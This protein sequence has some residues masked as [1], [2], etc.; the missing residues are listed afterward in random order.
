MNRKVMA[1]I[2]AAVLAAAALMGCGS[3]TATGLP[4][5]IEVQ[6]PAKAGGGTDVMARTLT[7]Q[8]SKDSGS[9]FAIV[10]NTDGAGLVAAEKVRTAKADGSE[11]MQWHTT[12]LIKTATGLYDKTADKDFRIIAVSQGTDKA[13]Y[14]LVVNGTSGMTTMADLV[15]KAQAGEVKMGVETGGTSHIIGGLLAKAAGVEFKYVESGSDTEKLTALVGGTIDCAIV[16][17]NQAKQYVESGKA[18]ALG[19]VGNGE[20]GARSSI[21]PDVKNMQEQ[22]IDCTFSMLNIFCGPKDMT[23]DTAK[24]IYDLY[25]AANSNKEVSDALNKAGFGM[26]FASYEDGPKMV[27]ESQE[28]LNS[29]IAD[30]GLK[31]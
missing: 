7:T 3:K 16:N 23:D 25:T 27:A 19:V 26:S 8:M 4:K 18:A 9:T 24:K 22:G 1:A 20:D 14:T 5:N 17:A 21:L 10:N 31:K 12:M 11:I 28:K 30:L 6:V 13:T 15:A 29:V 2:A